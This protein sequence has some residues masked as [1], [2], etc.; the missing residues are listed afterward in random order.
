A[1]L[2]GGPHVFYWK[3]RRW[4][5]SLATEGA[6]V[7]TLFA[8]G[9]A[10]PDSVK[11]LPVFV[12]VTRPTV[13]IVSVL[14]NPYAPG[15]PGSTASVSF[16]FAI[17]DASPVFPGRVPDELRSTFAYPSGAAFTPVSLTTTPPYTGASGAYVLSWNATAEAAV[18]PDGEY[19]VTLTLND[20]AGYTATSTY[21]FDVDTRAPDVEITSLSENA[22]VSTVPDSLRG[23]AFDKRGVDSLLV[24]YA[25]TRPYQPV[26]STWLSGDTLGFSVPLADS[27]P[28]EGA[29]RVD[30]RAVDV[31][32]RAVESFFNFRSD[33]TAPPAPVLDPF[34]GGSWKTSRY[35]LTGRADD[36]GDASFVRVYRNGALV[37]SV[38]TFVSDDFEVEVALVPG[39]NDLVAVLRD[40]AFNASPP[41]NT[42][43]VDFDTGAGFFAPAPFGPGD[44]FDVNANGTASRCTLRLF[45]LTGDLVIVLE[46]NGARQFY[47][48]AWDGT[49][50]SG[51]SV[52]KGP[53]VAVASLDYPD[54]THDVFREVFLYDPDAP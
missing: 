11:S 12:D 27:F 19:R 17:A 28:T 44:A 20:V 48:F 45:D 7:V 37:D 13:Q 30:F 40:A 10:N 39:R 42:V 51:K 14:P 9:A 54:G 46:D 5:G 32:G 38:S 47:A 33:A 35:P 15:A 25:D 41:S 49:N 43:T 53:L 3:G 2:T 26:V 31:F 36:G 50:G 24:R 52:K 6:Y 34:V 23:Y 29:H 4:D 8:R 21:L 16:S 18:P 22:S 1:Q